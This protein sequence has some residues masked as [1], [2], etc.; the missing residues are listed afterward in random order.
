MLAALYVGQDRDRQDLNLAEGWTRRWITRWKAGS[1]EIV[2]PVRDMAEVPAAVCGPVRS[3]SW[4]IPQRHRPG[5]AAM[6]S[7]R[8]LHG[9]E[10]LNERKL[11][12][13]LDFL[14]EVRDLLAQPMTLKSTTSTKRTIAHIPDFLVVTEAGVWLLDV[15]PVDLIGTEDRLRFAA[16]TEAALSCGWRYLVVQA[17]GHRCR[18]PWTR[19]RL[20][21]R[22]QR[23]VHSQLKRYPMSSMREIAIAITAARIKGSTEEVARLPPAA[24]TPEIIKSSPLRTKWTVPTSRTP[25]R[26]VV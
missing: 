1:S 4:R 19:C 15:R 16:T 10:S 2:C 18:P 20:A 26:P 21:V 13:A 9:F 7:T 11:L 22:R 14:G 3:F 23:H 17:G 6:V 24:P 12:L 25:R 5:L 8:R